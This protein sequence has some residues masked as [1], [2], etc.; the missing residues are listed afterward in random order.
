MTVRE[1]SRVDYY[2]VLGVHP[3]ASQDEIAATYRSL[4]KELHPDA[5]PVDPE[6][7]ERFKRVAAA[8]RVLGNS[9]SRQTYDRMRVATGRGGMPVAAPA[10]V[11]VPVASEPAWRPLQTRRG[12]RWAVGSGI[13]FIVL[14]LVV[15]ALVV[16]LQLHDRSLRERGQE[17][18]ATVVEVDG[19]RRLEFTTAD[20]R[21][22]QAREPRKTG[23]GDAPVGAEVPIRYDPDH[24]SDIITSESKVAR[25]VTLWIVAVKL[26]VGGAILLGFGLHRLRS[27]A[28]DTSRHRSG[29]QPPNPGF[30]A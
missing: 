20:G 27:D 15:A 28:F 16:A 18:V 26:V 2:S 21:V 22:V 29:T 8:Y 1:W 25:D 14:G 7:A 5:R 30:S 3:D 13:A 12:A 6:A 19:S 17:A 10:P 11:E 9:Q 23:T 24:P 4:V